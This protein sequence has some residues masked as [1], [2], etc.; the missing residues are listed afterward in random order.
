MNR[1]DLLKN[2]EKIVEKDEHYE[3]YITNKQKYLSEFI[4]TFIYCVMTH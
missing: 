3:N 2:Y 1:S 4:G